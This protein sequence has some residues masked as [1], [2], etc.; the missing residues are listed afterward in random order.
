MPFQPLRLI[1]HKRVPR[2]HHSQII[3][4]DHIARLQLDFHCVFGR[5]GVQCVE[6]VPVMRAR[7][8]LRRTR[9]GKWF[10]KAMGRVSKAL[11]GEGLGGGE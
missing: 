1:I 9:P 2:M 6:G 7:E 4:E 5:E 3:E 11:A 10:G 8:K